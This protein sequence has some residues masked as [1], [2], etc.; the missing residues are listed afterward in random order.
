[1]T[2]APA[3]SPRELSLFALWLRFLRFG[4]LAFGGPVVQIAALH[5][6][7]VERERWVDEARFRR[8]LAVYQA[9][10]GP[11][12]T[13]LCIWFGSLARGRLGGL[14]AGLGF[15][16]PGFALMLAAS[17]LLQG[18][19]PWPPWLVGAFAGMQAAVVALVARAAWRMWRS[20]VHGRTPLVAIATLAAGGALVGAW[21]A[22]PAAAGGDGAGAA[23][24]T[25]R[26]A[27]CGL[28]AGLLS[29]GGAYTV[30]PFLR[31]DA[32]GA[33]GWM[34]AGEFWN[35][36]AVGGVLPAPMVILGTWVGYAGGCL[37]GAV[38]VTLGIF[39]PAFAGPLL[40]GD[41]LERLVTNRRLHALL[42]GVTAA[43]VG[44]I[45]AIALQLVP[46]L[47]TPWRFALAIATAVL[48]QV[49]PQR[50]AVLPVM[51]GAGALGALLG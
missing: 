48:L 41:L 24:G 3:A 11:E 19:A 15:V 44:L 21:L 33:A 14:V 31:D 22:G 7:L 2:D 46:T 35:G 26:L 12:A 50:W 8:A 43:V 23:P 32:V 20:H 1:M 51:V 25:M 40:V 39:L 9:L 37:G 16:L 17:W 27:W 30:I 28:R 36:V 29:F 34:G 6:E 45:A 47:A 49:L 18:A 4:A 10:P 42:D 38:L 5:H 13:E